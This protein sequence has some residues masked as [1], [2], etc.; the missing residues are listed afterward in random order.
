MLRC[1]PP[2]HNAAGVDICCDGRDVFIQRA[3]SGSEGV[4][5]VQSMQKGSSADRVARV[6][7]VPG[8]R[9]GLGFR[10]RRNFQLLP[11]F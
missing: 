2:L 4:E 6:L 11:Q 3:K 10:V 1:L 5:V 8:H 9:D 7:V